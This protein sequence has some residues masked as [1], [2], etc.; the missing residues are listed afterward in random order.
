MTTSTRTP[1]ASPILRRRRPLIVFLITALAGGIAAAPVLHNVPD[2]TL[3]AAVA[4]RSLANRHSHAEKTLPAPRPDHSGDLLG[5]HSTSAL[6]AEF[7]LREKAIYGSDDRIEARST[8]DPNRLSASE[9]VVALIKNDF[10]DLASDGSATVVAPSFAQRMNVCT[11][12]RFARQPSAAFCTGFLV[13]PDIIATAGHCVLNAEAITSF[14]ILFDYALSSTNEPPKSFTKDKV[15]RASSLLARTQDDDGEDWALLRL[16][17]TAVGRTSLHLRTQGTVANTEDLY[18]IGCPAGLPLKLADGAVVRENRSDG[19]FVANLDTYGG[20]SGSPVFNAHTN[21]VEGILVRG[22]TDFLY[23]DDGCGVS[24]VCPNL[25]C[26]GEDCTRIRRLP[27]SLLSK[28]TKPPTH[29]SSTT[30]STAFAEYRTS[31]E[32]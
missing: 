7:R 11:T 6:F 3:Q 23:G 18:V 13:A 16:G 30:L 5:T 4:A 29:F 8:R 31:P 24:N 27:P 19:Y 1:F 15:Y 14:W 26:R 12:E 32:R 2:L 21:L 22:E 9:S 17:A 28:S 25:G 20:N 10:L